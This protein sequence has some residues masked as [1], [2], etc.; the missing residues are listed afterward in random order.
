VTSPDSAT[1]A[2]VPPLAPATRAATVDD[3]DA[4]IE[5]LAAP[6]LDDPVID[7]LVRPDKKRPDAVRRLLREFGRRFYLGRGACVVVQRGEDVVGAAL[8][9]PPGAK[10]GFGLRDSFRLVRHTIRIARLRGLWRSGQATGFL[11]YI[12][13]RLPHYYLWF[14]EP[15]D[16]TDTATLEAMLSLIT[17]RADAAGA[18]VYAENGR[19]EREVLFAAHGFDCKD[20]VT[21]PG[22]PS[23]QLLWR[24]PRDRA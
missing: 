5:A 23:V 1:D 20:T 6:L 24:S 22:G 14:V 17:A 18:P 15:A 16:P 8:C 11:N 19:P 21:L 9:L 13:P 12:H 4:V 7:Y 10:T 2:P 3:L